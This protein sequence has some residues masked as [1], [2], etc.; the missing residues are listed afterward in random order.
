MT[1]WRKSK[2]RSI[3]WKYHKKCSCHS[4]KA[5]SSSCFK[6]MLRNIPKTYFKF[7]KS[8]W[9]L[10]MSFTIYFASPFCTVIIWTKF[11]TIIALSL[12]TD[13]IS[14]YFNKR[15]TLSRKKFN[16]NLAYKTVGNA[17]QKRKVVTFSQLRWKSAPKPQGLISTELWSNWTIWMKG[18]W[19]H[20]NCFAS[21]RPTEFE[22]KKES[23]VVQYICLYQCVCRAVGREKFCN[24]ADFS[25]CV[26]ICVA[27]GGKKSS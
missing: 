1:S 16:N 26:S 8:I 25:T 6:K 18:V 10:K 15:F 20:R 17:L 14:S 19:Y 11:A 4:Y 21:K 22:R 7:R 2:E 23:C 5:F 12:I 24:K 13:E 9:K 27:C 3:N